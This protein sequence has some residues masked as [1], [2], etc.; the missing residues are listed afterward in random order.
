MKRKSDISFA[1]LLC[2]CCT[3]TVGAQ[4]K[5]YD[6]KLGITCNE[7]VHRGDSVTVSVDISMSGLNVDSE[8]SFTIVPLITTGERNREL[9]SVII[10]G[11]SRHRAYLR[12]KKLNGAGT[13]YAAYRTGSTR[14]IPYTVSVPYEAWM[15]SAWVDLQEELCGCGGHAQQV[16]VERL[17]NNIS[18]EIEV[19]DYAVQPLLALLRPEV[20]TVKNR[21]ERQEVRLQFP[22]GKSVIYPAYADNAAELDRIK[23]LLKELGEDKNISVSDIRIKGKASPEGSEAANKRLVSEREKAM[24]HYLAQATGS[25]YAITTLGGGED[26]EGFE[27]LLTASDNPYKEELLQIMHTDADADRKEALIRKLDQGRAYAE[28]LRGVFPQLRYVECTIDFVVRAFDDGKDL[29]DVFRKQP[30]R[31]SLEEMFRLANRYETSDPQFGDVFEVAVRMYPDN[32]VANLNAAAS[33][34]MQGVATERVA[35]YLDKSPQDTPQCRNARGVYHLLKGDY[36]QAR[37]YL[38][39]AAA[40]GSE[41]ARHN[42]EELARKLASLQ[43]K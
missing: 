25:R 5:F 33:L 42:L 43:G 6:G 19:R 28:L 37:Q 9:P 41:P 1:L 13:E 14:M 10:N 15:D 27:R 32:P 21:D 36:A 40:Q 35:A 26:W 24:M 23:G 12:Q 29:E 38:E 17:A 11:K 34:L 3:A 30:Q 8:R 2:A 39:A 22:V 4:Q 20:E 16:S 18:R 7:A 31:L